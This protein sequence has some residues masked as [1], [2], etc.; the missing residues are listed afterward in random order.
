MPLKACPI[1]LAGLRVSLEACSA[2]NEIMSHH[3]FLYHATDPSQSIQWPVQGKSP[4]A[5]S[6]AKY[7][8]LLA[9][10]PIIHG[11]RV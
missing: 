1:V 2:G 6:A 3:I 11:R 9:V 10:R 8:T 4:V 5:V 7:D